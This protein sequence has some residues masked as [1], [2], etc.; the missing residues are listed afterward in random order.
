MNIQDFKS[1]LNNGFFHA[2]AHTSFLGVSELK[3][4]M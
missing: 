1:R 3:E 2:L 4:K